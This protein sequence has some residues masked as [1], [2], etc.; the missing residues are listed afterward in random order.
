M[1]AHGAVGVDNAGLRGSCLGLLPID[2]ME[3]ACV[4]AVTEPSALLVCRV[5]WLLV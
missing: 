5:S 1:A 4:G 3:G 2:S